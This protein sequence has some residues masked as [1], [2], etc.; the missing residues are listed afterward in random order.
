MVYLI[1]S[2]FS[3]YYSGKTLSGSIIQENPVSLPCIPVWQ[4]YNIL[5][6]K[7]RIVPEELV[8]G[9]RKIMTMDE[10]SEIHEG[11]TELMTIFDEID[12]LNEPAGVTE[13]AV[14]D[15]Y[16]AKRASAH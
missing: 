8:R 6:I 5:T 4:I 1:Q 13:M 7:F 3:P 14:P 12:G 9:E 11:W 16:S 15:A 10:F 2:F